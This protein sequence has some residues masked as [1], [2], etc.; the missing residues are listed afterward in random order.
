[1]IAWQLFSFSNELVS[2]D[3]F[4]FTF[5]VSCFYL[6]LKEKMMLNVAT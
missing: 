5:H 4:P 6:K 3:F 2:V 1:M